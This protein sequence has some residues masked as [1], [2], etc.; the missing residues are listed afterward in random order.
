MKSR[1]FIFL[2][3]F[4]LIFSVVHASETNQD[5]LKKL[6]GL[7]FMRQLE[8]TEKTKGDVVFL[9]SNVHISSKHF[10]NLFVY[11]GKIAI[12]GEIKGNVY[13]YGADIYIGEKAKIKGDIRTISSKVSCHQNAEV[14][15]TL[16]PLFNTLNRFKEQWDEALFFY[17]TDNI[18]AY[19]L[20][21]IKMVV[22]MVISLLCLSLFKRSVILQGKILTC[23]TKD[24]FNRGLILYLMF[25][26][27][28]LVFTLSI[29]AF[30][31]VLVLIAA[32]YLLTQYGKAA[33]ALLIGEW[34]IN[35]IAV[36]T[37]I[38]IKF[39]T[40]ILVIQLMNFAPLM[41]W[42]GNIVLLP[43]ISFGMLAQMIINQLT[44]SSYIVV[45]TEYEGELN[46]YYQAQ[47]Y[48]QITKNL[49]GKK[50]G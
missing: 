38:Y 4:F 15:G 28:V 32:C 27:L 42:C 45:N 33:L 49:R 25:T 35:K 43:L 39:W 1:F 21:L 9:F 2:L 37:D 3:L 29:I 14:S 31:L 34:L 10:G 7:Y 13:A 17:Y 18:P 24:V 36:K 5:E 8:Q 50:E 6:R 12:D 11:K 26:A 40:G 22:Q 19:I 48:E 16:G 23:Q 44:N 20:D 30:P 46:F 47:L 41:D